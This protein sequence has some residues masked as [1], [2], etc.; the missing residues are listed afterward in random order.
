MS[1]QQKASVATI[2]TVLNGL[3]A[4]HDRMFMSKSIEGRPPFCTDEIIHARFEMDDALVHD[5]RHG[6]LE[7]KNLL[8]GYTDR[9]S[10]FR[11]K[12]RILCASRRL[13]FEP[14]LVER[15][16]FNH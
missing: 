7:L 1:L 8:S 3:L 4:R 6:K 2:E 9:E 11:K 14:I 12:N 13:V 16:Y 5:G 15:I 10:A